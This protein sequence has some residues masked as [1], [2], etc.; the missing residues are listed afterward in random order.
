[1]SAEIQNTKAFADVPKAVI[2]DTDNTIYP[3]E[4]AHRNAM[5][6]TED[7]AM[8]ILGVSREQ[9]Q[10]AYREARGAIK[11]H[12]GETASSHS[13]LLYFQRTIEILGLRTQLLLTL[14]L[15]QTYWRTFL[16][17]CEIFPSV[18]EFIHE[19]RSC[20]IHTAIITDLT[21]QIQFRKIIYFG[22]D[23]LFDYVVTSEEAGVDKPAIVPFEIALEKLKIPA[24]NIW[25]I[26]DSA[27]N[28]IRG[29]RAFGMVTLQKYHKGVVI[30]KGDCAADM[31]FHDFAYLRCF[32]RQR[33]PAS[34]IGSEKLEES[35]HLRTVGA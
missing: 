3:Y 21:S 26:G 6:A 7:K 17:S 12:L 20:G 30:G 5:M 11:K 28:D 4:P 23:T 1:M 2:F 29:A 35:M 9:F 24:K 19:I 8:E 13:R 22:L 15:E 34:D 14:D 33:F 32:F 10:I 18:R 27:A 16:S 25:M 31:V